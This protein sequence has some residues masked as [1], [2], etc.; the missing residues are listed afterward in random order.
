MSQPNAIQEVTKASAVFF[1]KTLKF[2]AFPDLIKHTQDRHKNLYEMCFQYP[3]RG[4]KMSFLY[5]IQFFIRPRIQ[6]LEKDLAEK[7][8]LYGS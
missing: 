7:L 8:L 3:T 6:S 2:Y 5:K 1:K 4:L